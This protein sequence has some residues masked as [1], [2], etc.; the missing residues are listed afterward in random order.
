MEQST[1]MKKNALISVYD[2]EGVGTLASFLRESGWEIFST[3][4]TARYLAGERIPVR[5]VSE[6]TG[7]AECFDGRV[8][9]LH[10]ALYGGIL[11]RRD[12]KSHLDELAALGFGAIDL[13]CVN[14]YP[15]FDK[16]REQSAEEELLEFIDIG[17]NAMLRAAAKNYRDVIALTDSADYAAVIAASRRSLSRVLA[18]GFQEVPPPALRGEQ[19]PVRGALFQCRPVRRVFI[20]RYGTAWGQGPQL[21]QHSGH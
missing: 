6:I 18:R 5:D 12:K 9:T 11:A 14:L 13:V 20:V 15:F 2:K 1:N 4:G 16:V 10:P 8:K 19:P 7:F 3:G 21:Q 17:G